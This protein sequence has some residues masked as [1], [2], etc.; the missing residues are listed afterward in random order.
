MEKDRITDAN[1]DIKIFAGNIS[2]LS[3]Q[4]AMTGWYAAAGLL[5]DGQ[6]KF[7]LQEPDI[8]NHMTVEELVQSTGLVQEDGELR[9]GFTV[10]EPEGRKT[11]S[12]LG[13]YNTNFEVIMERI[14]ICSATAE[15]ARARSNKTFLA[16]F[17]G[18]LG[19]KKD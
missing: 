6:V 5:K 19:L 4:L 1:Q 18:K 11:L 10:S 16:K 13:E 2:T 8:K 14:H 17:L 3:N 9:E 15:L 7:I 12:Y